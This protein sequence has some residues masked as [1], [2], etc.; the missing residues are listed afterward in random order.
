MPGR[1]STRNAAPHPSHAT[2]DTPGFVTRAT[3]RAVS[4]RAVDG[5]AA[6]T[7]KRSPSGDGAMKY[8][9]PSVAQRPDERPQSVNALV[10]ALKVH[11]SGCGGV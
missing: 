10:T 4:P 7:S 2:V 5:R 8:S 11:G 3:K 9:M 1:W 6:T